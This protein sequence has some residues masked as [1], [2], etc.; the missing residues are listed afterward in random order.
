MK[1]NNNPK[2]SHT[3]SEDIQPQ[4][5]KFLKSEGINAD[6][7]PGLVSQLTEEIVWL[8]EHGK[9]ADEIWADV[10][11]CRYLRGYEPPLMRISDDPRWVFNDDDEN[12]AFLKHFIHIANQVDTVKHT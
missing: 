8:R 6:Q 12:G 7:T 3:F 9:S 5:V 4:L 1:L 11:R 2:L 10:R